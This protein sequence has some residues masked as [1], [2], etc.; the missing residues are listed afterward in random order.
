[1]LV[2]RDICHRVLLRDG[3]AETRQG[4]VLLAFERAAFKAFEFNAHG[5]VIAVAATPVRGLTRMPGPGVATYKLQE[6][7]MAPDVEVGGHLQPSD[8]VKP[9]VFIP[10][11]L[12]GKE[13]LH[14][15]P[16]VLARRQTDRM[17]N[18]EFDTG[19][20]RSCAEIWRRQL[21]R[22]TVPALVPQP[23]K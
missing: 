4:L 8:V 18:N 21:V 16:A 15:I 14:L 13:P 23:G 2:A 7:A 10:V 22:E 20:I 9:R 11:Q 12:V 3:R 6:F 1:M 17:N 19:A 5:I